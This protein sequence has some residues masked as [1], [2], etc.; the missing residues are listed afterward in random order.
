MGSSDDLV[1]HAPWLRGLGLPVVVDHLGGTDPGRGL[2]QPGF[3]LL[4]EFLRQ[5]NWWIM[6]SNGDRRSVSGPPWDDMTPI[7]Q[8]LFAAAPDRCLW[9]GNW[10][11]GLSGKKNLPSAADLL[12]LLYRYLPQAVQRRKVLVDNPARLYSN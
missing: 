8:R 12:E 5:D 1:E 7:A 3:L 2:Q 10:P 11:P 6:L 4:L 9:A